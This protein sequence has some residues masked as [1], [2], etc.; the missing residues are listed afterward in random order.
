MVAWARWAA[1]PHARHRRSEGSRKL[2]AHVPLHIRCAPTPL[3]DLQQ[4]L[5][6]RV[7]RLVKHA[8]AV[9]GNRLAQVLCRVS[10]RIAEEQD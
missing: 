6:P 2:L 7:V 4:A 5:A 3:A 9:G 8:S 1:R 10:A